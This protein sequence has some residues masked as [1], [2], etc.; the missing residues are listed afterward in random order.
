MEAGTEVRG[1][2]EKRVAVITGAG[3][4]IDRGTAVLLVVETFKE[5]GWM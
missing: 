1:R 5:Y 2:L 3:S 4:G